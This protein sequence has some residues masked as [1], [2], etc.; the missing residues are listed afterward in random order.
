MSSGGTR[1]TPAANST[2]FV[3]RISF[4]PYLAKQPVNTVAVSDRIINP[5]FDGGMNFTLTLF[6]T[7]L[8]ISPFAAFRISSVSFCPHH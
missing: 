6:D 4:F 3:L 1:V 7:S 8:R 5:E 2:S